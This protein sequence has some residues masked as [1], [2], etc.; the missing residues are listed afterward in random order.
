MIITAKEFVRKGFEPKHLTSTFCLLVLLASK[1]FVDNYLVSTAAAVFLGIA[2]MSSVHHAE[3][4]AH[5]IGEGLGTLV[6][7]LSV[8]IIEVGL[9]VSLMNQVTEG[10]EFLARDTVFAAIMIITNGMVALCLILGGLKYKEQEFQVQGSKSLLVVLVTL[11]ALVFVFPNFT[12]TT[13]GPTYS[14]TQSVF[15]AVMCLLIYLSFIFFQTKSHKTYFEVVG[16]SDSHE[17]EEAHVQDIS[18]VDAWLSFLSLIVS[19]VA[20]IGLAKLISP[21][22]ELGIDYIGAPKS[23]VGLIIAVIVLLPETWAAV[24]A[25]RANRLQTSLNLALGSGIASIALTIPVVITYALLEGK[26]LVLGLDTKHLAFLVITFLV[27][28]LTLGTGRST[29]LQGLVHAVI[30]MTFF[31]FSMVP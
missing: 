30:L 25:S 19:L 8:T 4:I 9:I 7:A 1:P 27:G 12:L 17:K 14:S 22:I 23:M 5:K 18:N 24:N 29:L 21:M 15:V 28:N 11:S 16:E 2:V 31:T 13:E 26:N 20:V 6:L 3:I 10:A